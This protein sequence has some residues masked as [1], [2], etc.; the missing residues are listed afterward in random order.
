MGLYSRFLLPHLVHAACRSEAHA[1]ERSKLVPRATG[2]V[3]EIGVGSG[4]NLSWY[5]AARVERVVGLDPSAPMLSMAE[6]AAA[7]A[8]VPV[9][10]VEARAEA[11]P[12]ETG[13]FDT[14]VTTFSL[15]TIPGSVDALAEMARVLA[16]GGRLLFCEHGLAPDRS[17]RRWQEALTPAWS[18]LGGGCRLDRD[19]PALLEGAGFRILELETAYA[20]G[21]RP[22]A[23][24]Y[25]G[26]AEPT[27]ATTRPDPSAR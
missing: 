19:I 1:M 11:I 4:L 27:G 26:V 13:S 22:A 3:L 25:R 2:R 20:P 24:H 21:W 7:R 18:R 14:V 8:R 5:D 23:Y 10:F 17:V 9:E 12:R 15:C 6:R 16:P